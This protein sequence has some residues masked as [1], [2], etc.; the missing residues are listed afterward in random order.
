MGDT[1]VYDFDDDLVEG[2]LLQPDGT[3]IFVGPGF[4]NPEELIEARKH[5]ISEMEKSAEHL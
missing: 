3:P 5:F 1:I 2:S 4:G